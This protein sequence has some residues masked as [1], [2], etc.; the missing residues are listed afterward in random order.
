MSKAGT[1]FDPALYVDVTLNDFRD[2]IDYIDRCG[3]LIVWT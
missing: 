1:D 2:M 3:A